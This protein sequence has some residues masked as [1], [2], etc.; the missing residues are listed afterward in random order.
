MSGTGPNVF[1]LD[2]LPMKKE[3]ELPL[4]N[5]CTGLLAGRTLEGR[6]DTELMY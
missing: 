1:E 4:T 5:G 6:D 2:K 3:K